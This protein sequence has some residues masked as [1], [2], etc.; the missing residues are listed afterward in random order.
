ME[1]THLAL[2]PGAVTNADGLPVDPD[3]AA[4]PAIDV[5]GLHFSAKL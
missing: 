1:I 2:L 3:G 5:R 4:L